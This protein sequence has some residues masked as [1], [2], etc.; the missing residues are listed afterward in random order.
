MI[1]NVHIQNFRCFNQFEIEK[2]ERINLFGGKNNSGKT[3]LL[4]A[5]FIGCTPSPKTIITLRQIRGES[6]EFLKVASD[7]AWNYLFYKANENNQKCSI[8]LEYNDMIAQIEIERDDESLASMDYIQSNETD[9]MKSMLSENEFKKSALNIYR[10]HDGNK[11]RI[12]SVIASSKGIFSKTFE[13]TSIPKATFMPAFLRTSSAS[14]AEEYD[15][16]DLEDRSKFVLQCI[17]II[18]PTIV[19]IKTLTIGKP[20]IYIKRKGQQYLPITL[21]G[22]AITRVVQ[23]ILLMINNSNSTL[24]IDEIENGIHYIS[25]LELWRMLFKISKEFNIQIFATTHSYEMIKS[26][27]EAASEM[28]DDVGAYFE[29]TKDVRTDQFVAVKRTAD[30]LKYELD[31]KMELRGE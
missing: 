11:T 8:N 6:T 4:E 2:F 24:L 12:A 15:K 26:F 27:S 7:K 25:Q 28:N 10:H 16:S 22:E 21:F 17:Q 30:I 31:Q 1:K 20:N 13:H 19:H 23:I 3:S 29:F 9:D 5:L 18:D 14:L